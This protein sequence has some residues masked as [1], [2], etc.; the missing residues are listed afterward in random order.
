MPVRRRHLFLTAEYDLRSLLEGCSPEVEVMQDLRHVN[1][2]SL[3]CEKAGR[4]YFSKTVNQFA[5][6]EN[7]R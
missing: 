1:G 4:M 3:N 6:C 7:E 5:L 2:P